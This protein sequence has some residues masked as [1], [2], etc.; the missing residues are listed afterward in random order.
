MANLEL[1]CNTSSCV[2]S[3]SCKRYSLWA[4]NPDY[5]DQKIF[6]EDPRKDNGHCYFYIEDIKNE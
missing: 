6:S 1:V 2:L 5:K 4:M 3:I